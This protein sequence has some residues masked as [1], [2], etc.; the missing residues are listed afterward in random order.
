ML[1]VT[2]IEELVLVQGQEWDTIHVLAHMIVVI[3]MEETTDFRH[4]D[5]VVLKVHHSQTASLVRLITFGCF[6]D[7]FLCPKMIIH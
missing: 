2:Q 5:L 7:V 1:L 4:G 6:V 3:V